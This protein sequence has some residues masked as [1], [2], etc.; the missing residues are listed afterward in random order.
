[1]TME[2]TISTSINVL[3]CQPVHSN[4]LNHQVLLSL[5]MGFLPKKRE[6]F[7]C[8]EAI[9]RIDTFEI[10][11]LRM[12]L[13]WFLFVSLYL[14]QSSHRYAAFV[15]NPHVGVELDRLRCSMKKK[16]ASSRRCGSSVAPK[17]RASAEVSVPMSQHKIDEPKWKM[18]ENGNA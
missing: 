14:C 8:P 13:A 9:F 3:R 17:P 11:T 7:Q 4:R 12:P 18:M 16:L 10:C 15:L 5:V 6:S 1:M 2:T